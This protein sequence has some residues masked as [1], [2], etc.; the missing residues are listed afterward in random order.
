VTG[1]RWSPQAVGLTALGLLGWIALLWIMGL[2]LLHALALGAVLL[3]LIALRRTPVV[4]TE[5]AWPELNDQ[6]TDVGVR[7]E[8]ARLSW[9]M[10]GYE[11]RVQR[12]SVRRLHQIAA[13]R[14]GLR[15]LDLDDPRDYLACQAALGDR[16]YAVVS[17]PDERPMYTDFVTAVA[18]V[19]KL[20]S[21]KTGA[22][23]PGSRGDRR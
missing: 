15:G 14:L 11:S 6:R 20:V 1:P 9:S 8:V 4:N 19:E 12:Q 2:D 16:A 18:A 22:A 13:Y 17:E 7:R 3:A 21:E 5:Q 23:R 10:Q